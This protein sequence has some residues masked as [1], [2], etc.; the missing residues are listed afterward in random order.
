MV[1]ELYDVDSGLWDFNNT[2]SKNNKYGNYI[3]SKFR[4]ANFLYI[5][6][7][8]QA[9]SDD[10]ISAVKT[11]LRIGEKRKFRNLEK[12]VGIVGKDKLKDLFDK[13]LNEPDKEYRELKKFRDLLLDENDE[14]GI[15]NSCEHATNG[16]Q[17]IK[18]FH[19]KTGDE[20]KGSYL[21]DDY[22]NIVSSSAFRR[23][24]DKAQVY[25]LEEHD[26]V[27]SRLTHSNEVAAN[28]ELICS[29]TNFGDKFTFPDKENAKLISRCSGLLHDIGNPPFGHYG[30]DLI[31]SFFIE[32][33]RENPN[34]FH[35]K[36]LQKDFTKFDGNAQAFRIATKLQYFGKK[37][38]LN[39]P[40]CILGAIIKY[41]FC[42]TYD[43]GK[44]K[45]GYFI[46][47]K[48]DIEWLNALGV[49]C[50]FYRN[51]FA[52]ILEAADDISYITADLEDAIHK[53]LVSFM[54]FKRLKYKSEKSKEHDKTEDFYLNLKKIYD[55]NI[56]A[57]LGINKTSTEEKMRAEYAIPSYVEQRIFEKSMRPLIA[58]LRQELIVECAKQITKDYDK[59]FHEGLEIRDKGNYYELMKQLSDYKDLIDEL[60]KIV[61]T[62]YTSNEVSKAEVSGSV[63]INKILN[64]YYD[65]LFL[66]T[67][68]DY[69]NKE[70]IFNDD[71]SIGKKKYFEKIM[72]YVS[73]DFIDNFFYE[74]GK[75]KS[76]D[77]YYEKYKEENKNEILTKEQFDQDMGKFYLMHLLVDFVSGMTDSFAN[78]IYKVLTNN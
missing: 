20:Q 36:E 59:V 73:K 14:I 28:C 44:D 4:Y 65:A 9:V 49:Y 77:S 6:N 56:E 47:E 18:E 70:F 61:G 15:K 62:V 31:K 41:P 24:Q 32:K 5:D 66:D 45:F 23:L 34:F 26:F 19:P 25:S 52:I 39:L 37:R 69:E 11:L 51:P 75:V 12:I 30:E 58:K 55:E 46:S 8:S 21:F 7:N 50:D 2:K 40:A 1:E 60:K 68:V 13:V 35:K 74:M 3:V 71:L 10:E 27:R 29:Y 57:Y 33:F 48:D 43:F 76:N 64:E 17:E 22:A 72:T 38:S 67:K 54:S 78:E 63:I 42:S 53:G 16:L